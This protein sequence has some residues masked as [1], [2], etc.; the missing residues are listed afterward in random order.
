[1]V[2]FK[3]TS[4]LEVRDAN[5]VGAFSELATVEDGVL[6]RGGCEEKCGFWKRD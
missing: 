4:K 1:M 3:F 5:N 2:D 6:D